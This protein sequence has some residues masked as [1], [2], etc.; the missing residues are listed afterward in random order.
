MAAAIA[1]EVH[2]TMLASAETLAGRAGALLRRCVC[3]APEEPDQ[4]QGNGETTA[5]ARRRE[6]RECGRSG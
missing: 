4:K 5:P 6:K 1:G 3:W 2:Y